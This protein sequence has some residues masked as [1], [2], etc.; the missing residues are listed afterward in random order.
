MGKKVSLTECLVRMHLASAVRLPSLANL[1]LNLRVKTAQK[2]KSDKKLRKNYEASIQQKQGQKN[3]TDFASYGILM[4]AFC[5]NHGK[6]QFF[7][8]E[9]KIN[10]R[11]ARNVENYS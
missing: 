11:Y 4:K 3:L 9:V 5:S 2:P 7:Q 6:V 8:R 10:I 1:S